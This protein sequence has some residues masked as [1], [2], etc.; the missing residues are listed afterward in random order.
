MKCKGCGAEIKFIKSENSGKMMPCEADRVTIYT[1][2]GIRCSGYPVHWATC[3][4]ADKFRKKKGGG[5]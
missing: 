4:E 2:S 3:P 1:D 5:A